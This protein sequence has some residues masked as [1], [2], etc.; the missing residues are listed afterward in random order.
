MTK[1]NRIESTSRRRRPSSSSI[2]RFG[3]RH[4]SP[5]SLSSLSRVSR[6]ATTSRD[7]VSRRASLEIHPRRRRN[8]GTDDDGCMNECMNGCVRSFVRAWMRARVRGRVRGRRG[9]RGRAVDGARASERERATSRERDIARERE[10]HARRE[11]PITADERAG[12]SSRP[13]A[14]LLLDEIDDIDD[15]RRTR[16]RPTETSRG[17]NEC[18]K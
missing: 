16:R 11:R 2:A 6:R 12:R 15:R 1:S 7:D 8:V 5:L 17:M 9:G 10:R 4:L 18:M 3:D 13:V 14:V